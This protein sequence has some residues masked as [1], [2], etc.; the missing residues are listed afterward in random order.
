MSG[1]AWILNDLGYGDQIICLDSTESELT[2]KLQ[3]I[4]LKVIIWKDQY[5]VK[6]T[7]HIIYSEACNNSSELLLAKSFS[8]KQK[9]QRFVW[10]YFDFLSCLQTE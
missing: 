10:N 4:G 7:D 1:V 3:K 8:R 9:E 2:K 5:K 6:I